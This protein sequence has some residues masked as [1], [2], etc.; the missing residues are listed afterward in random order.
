MLKNKLQGEKDTKVP[1]FSIGR[2]PPRKEMVGWDKLKVWNLMISPFHHHNFFSLDLVWLTAA[3][4]DWHNDDTQKKV[5][6]WEPKKLFWRY[7]DVIVHICMCVRVK[8][9]KEGSKRVWHFC[10]TKP[11]LTF[12][13]LFSHLLPMK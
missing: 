1:N 11:C 2:K 8:E 9:G 10:I 13:W 5:S 6:E 7:D 12:F 3:T 4:S